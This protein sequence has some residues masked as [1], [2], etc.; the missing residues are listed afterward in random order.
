MTRRLRRHRSPTAGQRDRRRV[1]PVEDPRDRHRQ[2]GGGAARP[3]RSPVRHQA[4][5][6]RHGLLRHLQPRQR[7]PGRRP[8]RPHRRDRPV[9]PA[10]REASYDLDVLVLA[11]GFDAMTGPL[12]RI[13]IRGRGGRELREKWAA[14][15]V[16]YLGLATAGF[17]NMFLVAGPGSPSVL[18]N[19]VAVHRAAR[20]LDPRLPAAPARLRPHRHRGLRG[21]RGR[22]GRARE[23]DRGERPSTPRRTRGT[24]GPTSPA[25]RGSSCPTSAGSSTTDG[26]AR[27]WRN[28][29]MRASGWPDL[30]PIRQRR[31]DGGCDRRQPRYQGGV[32]LDRGGGARHP[33][34]PESFH[35]RQGRSHVRN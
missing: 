4:A 24:S 28:G 6:H 33:S 15:P 14:G 34:G 30:G 3:G 17:P 5:A 35:L 31:R 22:V 11:T 32:R 20:R 18:S 7:D 23:R 9:R 1:H 21:R 16:T 8:V 26:G 12:L 13:D 2:G 19:M 25:S 10:D 27:T 29:A